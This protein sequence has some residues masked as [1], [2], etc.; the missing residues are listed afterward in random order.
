MA[1]W[2]TAIVADERK[3]RPYGG[4]ANL[5]GVVLRR[6]GRVCAS[7][8]PPERTRFATNISKKGFTSSCSA[9]LV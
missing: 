3:G 7:H 5:R 6:M 8:P 4:K 9:D 1:L 2:R